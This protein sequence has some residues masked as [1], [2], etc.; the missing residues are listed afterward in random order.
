[1]T[2]LVQIVTAAGI[3]MASDS[4]LVDDKGNR[5]GETDKMIA[6]SDTVAIASCD[7]QLTKGLVVPDIKATPPRDHAFDYN[8][9]AWARQFSGTSDASAATTVVSRAAWNTF[10]GWW[11]VL[12]A[13]Y[14]AERRQ[15]AL[16]YLVGY[17][18]GNPVVNKITLNVDKVNK[19]VMRPQIEANPIS[20]ANPWLFSAACS[21]HGIAQVLAKSGQPYQRAIALEPT[22]IPK[23]L[24]RKPLTIEEATTL[25]KTMVTVEAETS[26]SSVGL[27]VKV[28]VIRKP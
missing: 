8:F 27:P 2:V 21:F 15:L 6:L 9:P 11:R 14:L 18:V 3:V 25:A 19:K 10:E 20:P 23:L 22:L 17:S 1:M 12:D 4:L 7:L 16:F 13:G 26:P 5:L 28:L 24:A